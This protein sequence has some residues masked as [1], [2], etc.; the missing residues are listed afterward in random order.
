[1]AKT[2]LIVDQDMLFVEPIR[3][4]LLC[5]GCKVLTARSQAEAERIIQATRPDLMITEVILEQLDS[6]FCL[7]WQVKNKYPQVPIIMLSAVTWHTGLY[8]GLS[9]PEDRN[10]IKADVFLDKPI[11]LEELES[12]IASFLQPAKAA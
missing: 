3:Q 9:T 1:M 6:G 7:A 10:W 4:K 12:A 2:I 11:R 8:F 5:A